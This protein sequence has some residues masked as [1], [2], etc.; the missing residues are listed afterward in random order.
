MA[1]LSALNHGYYVLHES[2]SGKWKTRLFCM[3]FGSHC[4]A[5]FLPLPD[6]FIDGFFHGDIENILV[7]SLSSLTT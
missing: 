2:K 1:D 4:C 3:H 7:P 5:N 6:E